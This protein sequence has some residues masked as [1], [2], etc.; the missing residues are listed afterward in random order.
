MDCHPLCMSPLKPP[1][2]S[3]K[4]PGCPGSAS[5]MKSEATSCMRCWFPKDSYMA[6]ELVTMHAVSTIER[7]SV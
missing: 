7:C 1:D 6:S 5:V 4:P 2:G 3:R